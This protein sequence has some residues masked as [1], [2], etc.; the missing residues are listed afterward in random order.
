MIL[1]TAHHAITDGISMTF[2]I[3]DLLRALAGELLD[4]LP[5]PPAQESLLAQVPEESFT[6]VPPPPLGKTATYIAEGT[7]SHIARL[8]LDAALTA[9]L[10]E[11]TRH[12]GVTVHAALCAAIALAGLA[13]SNR[14]KDT[15]VRI[16]FPVD[17]RKQL[18]AGEMNAYL[19]AGGRTEFKPDPAPHLWDWA[20]SA[21]GPI[22]KSRELSRQGRFGTFRSRYCRTIQIHPPS[23]RR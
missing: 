13:E 10:R 23:A 11:R 22:A 9:T 18:G 19:L 17:M 12:E 1:I 16:A 20:R 4:A 2:V 3:R 15:P 21:K 8:R 6:D 7:R 5:V 14:W